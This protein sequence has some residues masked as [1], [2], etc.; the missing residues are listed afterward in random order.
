[1]ET[2][3]IRIPDPDSG[4]YDWYITVPDG[5]TPEEAVAALN[6]GI[7]RMATLDEDGTYEWQGDEINTLIESIGSEFVTIHDTVTW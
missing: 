7:E 2:N 6:A 5:M 4:D 3:I 1:M